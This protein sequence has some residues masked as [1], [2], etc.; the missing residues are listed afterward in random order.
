MA[1][2]AIAIRHVAFEDLGSFETILGDLDYDV[3][4]CDVGLDRLD[5]VPPVEPDLLVVLGG[6]IGANEDD[7]YPFLRREIAIIETRL[8][9]GRP[10]LGICLGAQLAAR[11]LGARVYPACAKEIGFAPVRLSAEGEIS[12][13]GAL[14]GLPVL[15]WHGD[16]FDL[17]AGATRLASTDICENQAF[18]LGQDLLA[19]Q[20]HPEA[21]E[22]GFE[23]WLIG[24]AHELGSLGLDI[25]R[26]RSDAERHGA[27]LRGR[28]RQLITRWVEELARD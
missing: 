19:M 4:Y 6:P 17:P 11:A 2:T 16:T 21:S 9:A 14:A 5:A 24:H 13:L 8:A 27:E 26:L 23:R 10:T 3:R 25:S 12:C 28:G 20:F 7:K 1:R 22:V 18:S 15:H